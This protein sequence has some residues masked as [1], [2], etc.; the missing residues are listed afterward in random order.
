MSIFLITLGLGIWAALHSLSASHTVKAW[1]AARYQSHSSGWYRLAYNGFALVSI[2]PV[3]WLSQSLPDQL[4]YQVPTWLCWITIP[5]QLA[6]ALGAI[7]TLWQA[8]L[9]RFLGLRQWQSW[10]VGQV[11]P[12]DTPTLQQ[13]GLYAWVRHPLYFCSLVLLWLMPS[14]SQNSLTFAL[15]CTIYFWVGSWFEERKLLREFGN[16]YALYQKRVP[17]LLPFLK[18][19]P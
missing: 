11:E 14:Q 10:R 17:R 1:A 6:A 13:A 4:I 5:V 3:W 2:L 9:P 12:D 16:Q 8:D 18:F 15:G 19:L 7:Q